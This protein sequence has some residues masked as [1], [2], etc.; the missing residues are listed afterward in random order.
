MVFKVSSSVN[1]RIHTVEVVDHGTSIQ[2]FGGFANRPF[3]WT[4][5]SFGSHPAA[6]SS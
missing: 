1:L 6:V 4:V 2:Q 5:A 3:H